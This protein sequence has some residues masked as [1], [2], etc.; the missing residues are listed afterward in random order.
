M[1]PAQVV[2]PRQP[3]AKLVKHIGMCSDIVS[4]IGMAKAIS[5]KQNFTCF[6]LENV[7]ALKMSWLGSK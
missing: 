6:T 5:R 2:L 3:T 4:S 1:S 7:T